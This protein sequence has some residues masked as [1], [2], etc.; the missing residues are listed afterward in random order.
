MKTRFQI[1]I[2]SAALWAG[3]FLLLSCEGQTTWEVHVNNSTSANTLAITAPCNY[4]FYDSCTSSVDSGA[5]E[6]VFTNYVRGG[7][8]E[9]AGIEDILLFFN[10]SKPNGNTLTTG[11]RDLNTIVLTESQSW[12]GG[13]WKHSYY[14]TLTDQDF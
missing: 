3:A 6:M 2:K 1:I 14:I 9:A 13:V 10:A 7:Q 12:T 11:I 8:Q 5:Y 4:S